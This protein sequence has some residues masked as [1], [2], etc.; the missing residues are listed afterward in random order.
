MKGSYKKQ[1]KHSRKTKETK[2]NT[3]KDCQTTLADLENQKI[4]L[5]RKHKH[6]KKNKGFQTTL[7]D[8]GPEPK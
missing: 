5:K 6:N 8:V 4:M 7:A 2:K 1:N 3:N